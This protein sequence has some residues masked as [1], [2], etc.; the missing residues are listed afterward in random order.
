MKRDDDEELTEQ[1]LRQLLLKRSNWF[2]EQIVKS[3]ARYGYAFVTPAMNRLFANMPRKPASISK[4]AR[5]LAVSRQAVHQTVAEAC[6]R[7]LLE[8]VEDPSD[9]RVRNVR[10]TEKGRAMT[11][12][13]AQSARTIEAEL[14][15]RL[16]PQDLAAL[17]RILQ[18]EW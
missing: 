16:G 5:R 14:E 10:F 13:A 7:G 3:A 15:Q 17:R 1:N 11:R 6:R 9:A 12:S 2:E 8:L 18:R 4:L